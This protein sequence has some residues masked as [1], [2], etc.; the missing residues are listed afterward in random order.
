MNIV[1]IPSPEDP[2]SE[3]VGAILLWCPPYKRNASTFG[4]QF[5]KDLWILYKAGVVSAFRGYGIGGFQRVTDV[6]EENVNRMFKESLGPRGFKAEECGF[7]QMTAVNTDPEF[8]AVLK[9][10]GFAR[11]LLQWRIDRHWEECK[12]P[13]FGTNSKITPVILD[14]TTKQGINAYERLGFELI[15]Q[16]VPDT[17]TDKNGYRLKKDLSKDEKARLAA[18]AKEHCIMRIMIKMPPESKEPE[19]S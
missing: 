8:D 6:F 17:G 4:L 16:Y 12:D 10:K 5:I 19:S 15:N 11:Q 2:S 3:L 1:T 14:T 13:K 9:G 18:E 7:V